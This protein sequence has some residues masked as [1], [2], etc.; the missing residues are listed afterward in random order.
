MPDYVASEPIETSLAF[1]DES[2]F[3]CNLPPRNS[4]KEEVRV[5]DVEDEYFED[6]EFERQIPLEIEI[7]ARQ[8]PPPKLKPLTQ[9]IQYENWR[10]VRKNMPTC[11][12]VLGTSAA[13]ALARHAAFK[14]KMNQSVD[15]SG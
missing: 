2:I 9:T 6:D 15:F 3:D 13:M 14:M 7:E 5:S 4:S 12:G 8:R 10:E 11:I 1:Q